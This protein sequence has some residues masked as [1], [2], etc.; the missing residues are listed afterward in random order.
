[1]TLAKGS[2]N[3]TIRVGLLPRLQKK[4]REELQIRPSVT[5]KTLIGFVN[6][7]LSKVLDKEDFLTHY[8]PHISVI[9]MVDNILYLEDSKLNDTVQIF[10]KNGKLFCKIDESLSCA[11][12]HYA[13]ATTEVS[14]LVEFARL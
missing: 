4:H 7:L 8:L 13:M 12:V 14:S 9:G 2:K 3:I 5:E 1:M 11:H 10:L 6:E